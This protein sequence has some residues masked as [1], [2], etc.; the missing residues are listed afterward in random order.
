M[1]IEGQVLFDGRGFGFLVRRPQP[2]R[3]DKVHGGG[4]GIQRDHECGE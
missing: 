3:I 4:Q 1:A 2:F